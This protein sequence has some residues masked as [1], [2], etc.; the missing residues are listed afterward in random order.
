MLSPL[1]LE[2]IARS[3]RVGQKKFDALKDDEAE[4]MMSFLARLM[5]NEIPPMEITFIQRREPARLDLVIG[6]SGQKLTNPD[7]SRVQEVARQMVNDA[8]GEISLKVDFRG[9]PKDGEFLLYNSYQALT[10]LTESPNGPAQ[11][12]NIKMAFETGLTM[13]Q[14]V[15]AM[16]AGVYTALSI[17][18]VRCMEMGYL[19]RAKACLAQCE[20]VL[21]AAINNRELPRSPDAGL[22]E[23]IEF[24]GVMYE[25]CDEPDKSVEIG[26]RY[27]NALEN[28][29]EK[30]SLKQKIAHWM[31]QQRILENAETELSDIVHFVSKDWGQR[32]A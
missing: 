24:I 19:K 13:E 21:A 28:D 25:K 32:A 12:Q 5:E 27:V 15:F 1:T 17:Y 2:E 4:L 23:M 30:Y 6:F 16:P 29:S 3:L 14:T 8:K 31:E 22:L 10:I 9:I 7:I 26:L 11:F 20:N 18:A